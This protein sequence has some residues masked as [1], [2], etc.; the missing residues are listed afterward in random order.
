M[1]FAT[2]QLFLDDGDFIEMVKI[3]TK[4][5][6]DFNFGRKKNFAEINN[7]FKLLNR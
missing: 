7:N 3:V 6:I 2:K 5:Q 4:Q 1:E